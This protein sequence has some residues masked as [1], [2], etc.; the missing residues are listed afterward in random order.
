M[1][2]EDVR[3]DECERRVSRPAGDVVDALGAVADAGE[4]DEVGD[5]RGVFLAEEPA[6]PDR[7]AEVVHRAGRVLVGEASRHPRL[8]EV[9][10]DEQVRELRVVALQ[11]EEVG[12]VAHRRLV[13]PGLGLEEERVVRRK[14][15]AQLGRAVDAPVH[16]GGRFGV[17]APAGLGEV[18][19]EEPGVGGT[20]SERGE[21]VQ[22]GPERDRPLLGFGAAPAGELQRRRGRRP[23]ARGRTPR[24]RR[25]RARRPRGAGRRRGAARRG[26]RRGTRRGRGRSGRGG[27]GR[28]GI[29]SG[30]CPVLL[31]L[32]GSG[33]EVKG[34]DGSRGAGARAGGRR[35][36]GGEG[37]RWRRARRPPRSR[38]ARAGGPPP[39]SAGGSGGRGRRARRGGGGGWPPTRGEAAGSPRG[40]SS[41]RAGR[42][43]RGGPL[44]RPRGLSP[45]A[46][47]ALRAG[48]GPREDPRGPVLS[49]SL[50]M[51]FPPG[52]GGA[53]R[54]RAGTG[55]PR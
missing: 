3:R 13:A 51:V 10:R 7:P 17:P 41:G 27:G 43:R 20:V 50:V 1:L 21:E 36:R 55:S 16:R 30:S 35:D 49:V 37:G 54:C 39:R 23:S 11:R 8:G 9:Q 53:S 38:T 14:D 12:V 2:P 24:A 15:L 47:G 46:R 31:G 40:G 34:C 22:V 44:A 26:G 29:R 42:A 52:A 33:T 18:L 6:Q 48:R 45:S 32:P 5:D 28:G 25:V 4:A 19:E